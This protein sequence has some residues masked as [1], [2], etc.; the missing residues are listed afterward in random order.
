MFQCFAAVTRPGCRPRRERCCIN[1]NPQSTALTG[2]CI[3]SDQFAVD[4]RRS[5]LPCK[6][7]QL[8]AVQRDL[9]LRKVVKAQGVVSVGALWIALI[10]SRSCVNKKGGASWGCV[11]AYC[12]NVARSES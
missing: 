1:V 11:G 12:R 6:K 9:N 10:W 4:Y 8:Q 3:D 5:R 7:K 2:T